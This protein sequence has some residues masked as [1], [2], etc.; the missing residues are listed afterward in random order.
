MKIVD[1]DYMAVMN[2]TIKIMFWKMVAM[3]LINMT[4][5]LI[6]MKIIMMIAVTMIDTFMSK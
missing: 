3:I 4:V 2:I 1:N 6:L 5:I